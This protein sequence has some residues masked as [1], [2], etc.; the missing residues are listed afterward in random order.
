[1]K[2]HLILL[3]LILLA[4]PVQAQPADRLQIV[5]VDSSDFPQ[6]RLNLRAEDGQR[7]PYPI[8][9]LDNLLLRENGELINEY[10]LTAV[11]VGIDLLF[12][13]DVNETGAAQ[14]A[15]MQAVVARYA[16]QFMSLSDLDQVTVIVPDEQYSN[17]R[18]LLQDATSPDGIRTA[19]DAY[20]PPAEPQTTPLQA[21][22]EMGLNHLIETAEN[23]RFQ[24]LFLLSDANQLDEQLDF[25]GLTET[26]VAHDIPLY[27]AII[28]PTATTQAIN[29]AS[30]LATA[31]RANYVHAPQVSAVDSFYLI[32]QR[33]SNQVQL[34]YDSPIRSGGPQIVAVTLGQLQHTFTFELTL[35]PAAL[36]IGLDSL[37]LRQG[38]APD[39]PL[40]DLEPASIDF[41]VTVT[42][43]DDR[44]RRL[45]DFIWTVNEQ[46]QPPI[47][48]L[49]PDENGRLWLS[50]PIAEL[51]PDTYEIRAAVR[52]EW[53]QSSTT[54][55]LRVR[56]VAERPPPPTP[57]PAPTPA[58]GILDIAA[59]AVVTTG[60]AAEDYLLPLLMTGLAA[61]LLLIIRARWR[62]RPAAPAKPAPPAPVSPPPAPVADGRLP[63]LEL[64]SESAVK[65]TEEADSVSATG[66]GQALRPLSAAH[67]LP[68][69][70]DNVTL[71][72]DR[73]AVDIVFSDRSVSRL[74]ARIRRRD[75]SYWLYDEGSAEGTELNYE[76][77]GLAPRGLNDGDRIHLGRVQLRFRLLPAEM[78]TALEEEE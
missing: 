77:L 72:R 50:W 35:L 58:P 76:R 52:D 42:W 61:L 14:L 15:L 70:S 29:S 54:E 71:G 21:M 66:S 39:T 43:P 60:A 47:A 36:T 19:V 38:D 73:Q 24:A 78:I 13:L 62:R 53:G 11:P 28:G 65:L 41:P 44:P 34:R 9:S 32:W 27:T 16:S 33:Q 5:R 69:A 25:D 10:D 37:I 20:T 18:F 2:R 17:G 63:V 40:P 1:M 31:S 8:G 51:R 68:L 48:S 22:M 56:I 6:M 59:A 57:T 55:P 74:H 23:G 12:V 67:F 4:L 45:V 49:V 30:Q 7:I 26:A 75:N 46:P 3:L 64:L